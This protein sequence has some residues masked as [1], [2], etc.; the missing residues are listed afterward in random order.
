[1]TV[2]ISRNGHGGC[3]CRFRGL[4]VPLAPLTLMRCGGRGWCVGRMGD[5]QIA[6]KPPRGRL[7]QVAADAAKVLGV[8]PAGGDG[9]NTSSVTASPG[10]LSPCGSVGSRIWHATGVS[11][12]TAN[13]SRGRLEGQREMVWPWPFFRAASSRAAAVEMSCKA[14][15]VESKMV[16]SSPPVRPGAAPE[17]TPPMSQ[18]VPSKM[19]FL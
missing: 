2:L 11:F 15:P 3:R 12:N 5:Y 6:P 7:W 8:P 18:R 1:M 17:M 10:H 4:L 19:P 16:I 13:P 9:G 14:I